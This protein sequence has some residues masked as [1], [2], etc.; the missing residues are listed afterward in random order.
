MP[1]DMSSFLTSQ[2]R[3]QATFSVMCV[4]NSLYGFYQQTENR[5]GLCVARASRVTTSVLPARAPSTR[6][7]FLAYVAAEKLIRA[8]CLERSSGSLLHMTNIHVSLLRRDVWGL[9]P[10]RAQGMIVVSPVDPVYSK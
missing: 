6:R 5:R 4:G 10:R 9:R 7:M 1:Q 2:Y 3:A 8:G